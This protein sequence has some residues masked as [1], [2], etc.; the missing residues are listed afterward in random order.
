[1]SFKKHTRI[2]FTVL[3]SVFFAL[4]SVAFVGVLYFA[5]SYLTIPELPS[6]AEWTES[7]GVGISR[8]FLVVFY[9]ISAAVLTVLSLIGE[10]FST[11]LICKTRKKTRLYGIVSAALHGVYLLSTAAFFLALNVISR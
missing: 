7:L 10:G 5:I 8:A 3:N 4:A 6:D 2:V 11:L 1:M 9:I